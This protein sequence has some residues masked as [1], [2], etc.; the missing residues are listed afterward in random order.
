MSQHR[1]YK[2]SIFSGITMDVTLVACESSCWPDW[3]VQI[4]L[5]CLY[6]EE[7]CQEAREIAARS[8]E[9]VTPT[10]LGEMAEVCSKCEQKEWGKR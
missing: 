8:L 6:A 5:I 1:V 3:H 9:G 2:D 7:R 4:S 10:I